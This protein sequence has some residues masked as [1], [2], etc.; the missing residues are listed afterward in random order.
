MK[1]LPPLTYSASK[2]TLDTQTHEDLN[3]DFYDNESE[4]VVCPHLLIDSS[5]STMTC[6]DPDCYYT[7][8]SRPLM[9]VTW[10]IVNVHDILVQTDQPGHG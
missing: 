3:M 2:T 10:D 9:V 5:F 1:Q 6:A 8:G 4:T 7:T